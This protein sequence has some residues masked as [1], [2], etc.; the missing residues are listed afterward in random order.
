[1]VTNDRLPKSL[2]F[3]MARI[4]AKLMDQCQDFLEMG[5][6]VPEARVLI[7]VLENPGIR[8]GR[9]AEMTTIEL[10][11]LSHMLGRLERDGLISRERLEPDSR[12]VTVGLTSRGRS[13]AVKCDAAAM[14]HEAMLLKNLSARETKLIRMM[15]RKI[16]HGLGIAADLRGAAAATPQK[17][18]R[19]KATRIVKANGG[20][21]SAPSHWRI[22]QTSAPTAQK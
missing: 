21:K 16:A 9:L 11:T 7:V 6:S 22:R 17:S 18:K 3:L 1:M 20:D 19:G 10:S 15:I 8:V 5:L 13:L 12:T 14:R 4:V 2:P